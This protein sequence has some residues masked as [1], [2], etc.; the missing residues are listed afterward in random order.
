MMLRRN[1]LNHYRL[2]INISYDLSLMQSY[3]TCLL[4]IIFGLI[5]KSRNTL[6][7]AKTIGKSANV[8]KKLLMGIHFSVL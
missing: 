5:R 2:I 3:T 7:W 8:V 6:I 4:L 1:Y